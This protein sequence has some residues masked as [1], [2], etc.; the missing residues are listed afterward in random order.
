MGS[1]ERIIGKR[2]VDI[3]NNKSRDA[4]TKYKVTSSSDI[5]KRKMRRTWRFWCIITK[6][7]LIKVIALTGYS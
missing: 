1:Q 5:S 3:F 7:H 4:S 6:M 2:F